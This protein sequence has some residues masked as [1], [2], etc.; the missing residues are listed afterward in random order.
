MSALPVSPPHISSRNWASL[1]ALWRSAWGLSLA[2][3]LASMMAFNSAWLKVAGAALAGAGAPAAVAS[4]GLTAS[5]MRTI[6]RSVSSGVAGSILAASAP[7]ETKTAIR[8]L[9]SI[10]VGS[11]GGKPPSK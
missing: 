2:A 1:A 11:M 6:S 4:E 7:A 3:T 9:R 5:A 10:V 8:A